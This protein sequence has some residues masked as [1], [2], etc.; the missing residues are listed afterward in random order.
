MGCIDQHRPGGEHARI[1]SAGLAVAALAA[2]AAMTG[3]VDATD[4]EKPATT[5]LANPAA[6][7]CFESGGRYEIRTSAD[8][9]QTGVCILADNTEVDAWIYFREKAAR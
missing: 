9:A 2:G 3:C 8:G 6:V 4:S 7:F 1:R 5:G